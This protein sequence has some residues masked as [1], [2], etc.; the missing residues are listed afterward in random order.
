MSKTKERAMIPSV[1]HLLQEN[2]VLRDRIKVLEETIRLHEAAEDLDEVAQ[3]TE[4]E[5]QEMADLRKL[6]RAISERQRNR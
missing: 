4:I 3:Q 2:R 1:I 5:E 6:K